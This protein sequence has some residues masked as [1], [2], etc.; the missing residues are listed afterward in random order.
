MPTRAAPRRL[1][2][3]LGGA[4]GDVTRAL[5]LLCRLHRAYA[6][7]EI[8]WAVEPAAAPLLEGHPALHGAVVF[9]R[10]RGAAAFPPFLW[11]V[12]RL[13]VDCALDLQRHLKSGIV[14]LASGAP[15]R[16]GF[17]RQGSREGNFLFQTETLAPMPRFSSKLEQFLRFADHLGAAPAPVEFGLRL[18]PEEEAGV[19]KLLAGVPRPFAAFFVGST[20]DSRLWFPERTAQVVEA[21]RQRGLAAVLVGGPGEEQW[22]APIVSASRVP[23]L[24]LVGRTGLRQ[25]IGIFGRAR[26]GVG[27][28]CGPMHLAAAVGLPVVSLWGA[29]S[30]ARS[31]PWGSHHLVVEGRAECMPCYYKHCPIGRV[32]MQAIEPAAVLAKIDTALAS[33]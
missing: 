25:L 23:V 18:R 22:A 8:F 1:L 13:G 29:T 33:A 6:E 11:Q 2:I 9:D 19:E 28:D 20:A 32:C 24:D 15:R 14:S 16:I 5:P 31:A 27:P 4:I 10:R 17:H 21:L 12:R 30:A 7:A 3:V 26:V